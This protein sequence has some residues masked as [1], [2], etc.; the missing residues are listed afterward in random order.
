MASK[1]IRAPMPRAKRA[2]QFQPFD[3]LT[4]LREAIAAKERVTEPKR[5]LTEDSVAE[6]NSILS[7]LEKGQ[8][9]T[10]EYYDI[11]E[12]EYLQITGSVTKVDSFHNCLQIGR[13]NLSFSEIYHIRT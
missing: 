10:V 4:G 2:K 6:I 13:T 12:Q 11:H 7:Y 3:A 5:G 1:S 9:I 8:I